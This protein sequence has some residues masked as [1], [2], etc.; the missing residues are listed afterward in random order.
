[1]NDYPEETNLVRLATKKR[2]FR[3]R[4]LFAKAPHVLPALR[5][6][7][8]M[9]PILAAEVVPVDRRFFDV[10]I[11]D[12]ASQIPPAEA[13]GCLARAP[14]AVIAGDSRQLPPTAFFGRRA[15]DDEDDEEG[16]NDLLLPSLSLTRDIESLLDVADVL[17]RSEMLRWHYRSRDDRLI[18]FSNRHIYG[19]VLTTFPGTTG[20]SPL[21][22]C[23]IPFRPIS[24]TSRV[25]SNPDEVE[26]VVD[27]VL[28]S[29]RER[30][31]ETLGV[32]AL[33]QPMPTPSRMRYRNA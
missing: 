6:C 4:E 30:S 13:I 21:S 3:V 15:D 9:S 26:K 12:E 22:H 33:G 29:A 1:M 27:L 31:R 14:Q 18:A 19:G 24:G 32:I 23:E 7:W 11:F 2:R 5:P 10:V 25:R 17:L 8:T 16:N 20:R 28:T